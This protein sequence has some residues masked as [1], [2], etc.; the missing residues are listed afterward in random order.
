MMNTRIN[1][2]K[3]LLTLAVIT[4]CQQVTAQTVEDDASVE[5]INVTGVRG[6]LAKSS[7]IKQEAKSLVDSIS[8][9][10]LGRFPDNNV[11]DSLSHISGITVSRTRNGEAQYV[12]IRGL[13]PEFSIVTL[14]NRI[15]A[16]DDGGRNFAFDVL[17][18]ESQ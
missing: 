18:S 4:A 1:F 17:P 14:N 15:L 10:E 16:T 12:N 8:S 2:K 9:E 5:V 3:T 6:S 7:E 11:A 13:G